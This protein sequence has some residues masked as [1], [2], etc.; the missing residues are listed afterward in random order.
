MRKLATLKLAAAA[1]VA[2]G[3]AGTTTVMA[4]EVYGD[5]YCSAG[6]VMDDTVNGSVIVDEGESCQLG[7][8]AYVRGNVCYSPDYVCSSPRSGHSEAHAGLPFVTRLGS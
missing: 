4:A 7:L 1:A 8:S 5:V 3:M 2:M 6:S